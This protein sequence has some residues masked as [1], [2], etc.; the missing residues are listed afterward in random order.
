MLSQRRLKEMVKG[1]GRKETSVWVFK[2]TRDDAANGTQMERKKGAV[3]DEAKNACMLER[4]AA[5]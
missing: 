1:V 3:S 5:N 4:S 2:E